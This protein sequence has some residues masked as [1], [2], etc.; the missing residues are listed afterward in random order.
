MENHDVQVAQ[1]SQLS[2][3]AVQHGLVVPT[4]VLA[5]GPPSP[6]LPWRWLWRRLMMV[7][8]RLVAFDHEPAG[9][10]A[11]A[12]DLGQAGSGASLG[13]AAARRGRVH[14]DDGG[15]IQ[16]LPQRLAVVDQRLDTLGPDD[17]G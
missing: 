12:S 15:A 2:G 1:S 9:I 3:V 17:F 7:K 11:A 14:A 10:D 13:D 8:K 4:L 6:A 5:E 16:H